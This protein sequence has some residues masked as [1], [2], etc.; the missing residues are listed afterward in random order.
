[1]FED[2]YDNSEELPQSLAAQQEEMLAHL[3]KYSDHDQ[4]M[5]LN[6]SSLKN[7]LNRA[8]SE[9]SISRCFID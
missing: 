7:P 8:D 1:M 3:A 9:S 4:Y 6:F 5:M 2:V